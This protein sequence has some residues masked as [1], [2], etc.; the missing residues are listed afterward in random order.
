MIYGVDTSYANGVPAWQVAL[1]DTEHVGF[2]IA[3]VCYGANSADD[4][5]PAFVNAHDACLA[6]NVPFGSYLFWLADE[7]G[8]LQAE[9]FLAQGSGRFGEIAPVV[10]VE[11]E[12]VRTAMS[13]EERIAVLAATLGTIEKHLGQPI[14]YTNPDTWENFFGG[15]D[16]FSGH[17]LWLADYDT[18]PGFVT[19]INGFSEVVLHQF[20][21]GHGLPPIAGLSSPEN[22][23][24]RDVA[25]V[26]M[27]SLGKR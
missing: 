22:N 14:I 9:H 1:D 7:D 3:R 13:V 8:T 27:A 25:M 19:P 12:S 17:R 18:L 11:E 16:A 26:P 20:S 23:V 5:G 2:V 6:R 4:D 21:D 24:D 15:T 10:D